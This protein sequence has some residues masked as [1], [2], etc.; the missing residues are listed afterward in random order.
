M[1]SLG[2]FASGQTLIMDNVFELLQEATL[3]SFSA[4]HDRI[5]A[6][7]R[8]RNLARKHAHPSE[9]L[10]MRE[11]LNLLDLAAAEASSAQRLSH[12]LAHEEMFRGAQGVASEAAALAIQEE[13]VDLAISLLEQG[14]SII[15]AQL[16]RYRPVID[17]VREISPELAVRL[18]DLGVELDALVFRGERVGPNSNAKMEYLDDN[19]SR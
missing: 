19:A 7:N 12:R 13:N 5:S 9:L 16:S 11:T 8:W 2:P 14:R 4:T 1:H 17:D 18:V 3:H 15:F 10:A 6:A